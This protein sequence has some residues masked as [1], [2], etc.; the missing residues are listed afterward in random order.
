MDSWRCDDRAVQTVARW[1]FRC[2]RRPRIFI[3]LDK[4][5]ALYEYGFGVQAV[6]MRMVL[7]RGLAG[8]VQNKLRLACFY[9]GLGNAASFG[10]VR[11][12]HTP[13]GDSQQRMP[14]SLCPSATNYC[15]IIYNGHSQLVAANPK[16]IRASPTI[17]T[18]SSS[19]T[20]TSKR[21]PRTAHP[22]L[23]PLNVAVVVCK[24]YRSSRETL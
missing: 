3:Y 18:D 22:C 13:G 2:E 10:L 12:T 16:F 14:V 8:L 20:C 15:L 17:T 19:N 11:H 1:S 7:F 4:A 24:A 21:H 9:R 23:V 6:M 5:R